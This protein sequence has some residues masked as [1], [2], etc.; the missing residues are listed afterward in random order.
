MELSAIALQYT[1]KEQVRCTETRLPQPL[2]HQVV[3][4]ASCSGVS[5]GTEALIF[6]GEIESGM[7]LDSSLSGLSDATIDYPFTYGYAWV[8]TV[9]HTGA[10]VSG[11]VRGDRIFAFAPHQSRHILNA[12]DCIKIPSSINNRTA[13]LLPSM[14]TA[15]SI[16]HDAAPVAGEEITVFGQGLIG[17]LTTWLLSQF[18]LKH[19]RAVDPST[20]R[21]ALSQSLG[22][23]ETLTPEELTLSTKSDKTIEVSGNPA[24]LQNAIANTR[25]HGQVIIASWYGTRTANLCLGTHFHRGRIQL[26][27]SQV[28]NIGPV[29][30]GTWNKT[31]RLLYAMDRLSALPENLLA[32][33]EIPFRDSPNLYPQALAHTDRLTHTYFTYGE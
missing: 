6:R 27:S 30:R 32:A 23:H 11:L 7:Q 18:P 13:T 5:T 8:G 16:V 24:A 31:R 28:S 21:H 12:E 3:A 25:D 14:E 9:E 4:K 20:E 15:L 22:V 10:E 17:L 33:N 1:A 2:P 29:L 26:V 19:L